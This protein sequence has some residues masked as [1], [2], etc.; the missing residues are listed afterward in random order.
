MKRYIYLY[1]LCIGFIVEGTDWFVVWFL[2]GQKTRTKT[3]AKNVK[4][5]RK[6]RRGEATYRKCKKKKYFYICI[7]IYIDIYKINES[8]ASES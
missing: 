6:L 5:K 3:K 8:R 2:L 7:R 1:H 4:R